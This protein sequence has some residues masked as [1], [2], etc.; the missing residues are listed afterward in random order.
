MQ[1]QT[2]LPKLFCVFSFISRSATEKIDVEESTGMTE[3]FMWEHNIKK[4]QPR[5]LQLADKNTMF[6]IFPKVH[7]LLIS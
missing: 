1:K 7:K 2:C 4:A 3:T 5:A 6:I